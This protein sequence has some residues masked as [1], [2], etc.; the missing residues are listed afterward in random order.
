MLPLFP[1]NVAAQIEHFL[2]KPIYYLNIRS[3]KGLIGKNSV[4]F[5]ITVLFFS[6]NERFNCSQPKGGGGLGVSAGFGLMLEARHPDGTGFL[7]TYGF[8]SS[9]ETV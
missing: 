4:V 1:T 5:S 3:W 2:T 7:R 6:T 9:F 8:N